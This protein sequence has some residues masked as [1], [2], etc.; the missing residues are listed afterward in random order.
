MTKKLLQFI[1]KYIKL[2][3]IV[4][5]RTSRIDMMTMANIAIDVVLVNLKDYRIFK[6]K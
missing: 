3:A 5:N 4:N 2:I 1:I 6:N